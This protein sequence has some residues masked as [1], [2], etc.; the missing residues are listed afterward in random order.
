MIQ[1]NV[2][3]RYGSIV[4]M[5]TS[6]NAKSINLGLVDKKVSLRNVLPKKHFIVPSLLNKKVLVVA[7][8]QYHKKRH[9]EETGFL[10]SYI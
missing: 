5:K 7:N 8:F 2:P 3:K 1:N 4:D 9:L 6:R 10:Q